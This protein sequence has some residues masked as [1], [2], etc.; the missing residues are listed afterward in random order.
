MIIQNA[1]VY[2]ERHLFEKVNLRILEEKIATVTGEQIVPEAKEP[3]MDATGYKIIPGLVDIHCHGAVGH[4]FSDGD[5]EGIR[6][7]AEYEAQNGVLAICPTTMSLSEAQTGKVMQSVR[8]AA[9]ET[10]DGADIAGIHLEGPFLS[11]GK[12][13]AQNREHLINPVKT[14]TEEWN[15]ASGNLVKLISLAPELPGAL[16]FIA[17]NKE[18]FHLSVAHTTA[19]YETACRAFQAGA[20]HITHLFNGMNGMHHRMPGPAIAALEADAYAEIICDGI[21][22]H[23]AMIRTVFRMFG[24]DRV[25]LISDSMRAT[26]LGDGEFELGGQQVKVTGNKAVLAADEGTIAGS[27]TNLFAAL[28]KAI[29]YGVPVE[30]AVRAATENPAKSIGR[31]KQYGCIREG[32]YANLLFLDD[33]YGLCG[34]LHRGKQIR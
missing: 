28:Q 13:G 22:I 30:E 1:E 27:V 12:A 6:R 5:G 8:E 32:A 31:E 19:D 23:P 17:E 4:D 21:H 7:I 24:A 25:V 2:T 34:V 33:Q 3:V 14:L 10:G 26:G 18:K 16:D 9:A 29:E 11:A 20:D 15:A